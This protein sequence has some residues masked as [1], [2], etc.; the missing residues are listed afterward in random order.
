[1]TDQL[2]SSSSGSV[3]PE[4]VKLE[5]GMLLNAVERLQTALAKRLLV[6]RNKEN[7]DRGDPNEWPA[8]QE[9]DDLVGSSHA[10]FWQAARAEAGIEATP[11]F[12]TFLDSLYQKYDLESPEES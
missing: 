11:A 4:F 8:Q 2:N 9:W 10:I 6:E 12:R 1:M 3:S 5:I 7:A